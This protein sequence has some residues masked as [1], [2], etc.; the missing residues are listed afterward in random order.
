MVLKDMMDSYTGGT[1]QLF[2]ISPKSRT[3]GNDVKLQNSV[4]YPLNKSP[5][6][7]SLIFYSLSELLTFSAKCSLLGISFSIPLIPK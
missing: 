7:H 2:S 4:F 1:G 3:K 5:S 6:C